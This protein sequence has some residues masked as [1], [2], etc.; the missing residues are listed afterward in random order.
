M[1]TLKNIDVQHE[2]YQTRPLA[3]WRF[4]IMAW[5]LTPNYKKEGIHGHWDTLLIRGLA[6]MDFGGM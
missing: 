3:T 1:S 4:F 6:L 2:S 5:L